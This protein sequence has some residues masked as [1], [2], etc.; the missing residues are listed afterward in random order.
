MMAATTRLLYF[1]EITSIHQSF[2]L[3]RYV[4]DLSLGENELF[5]SGL[6]DIYGLIFLFISSL[7]YGYVNVPL[8]LYFDSERRI[9]SKL[10]NNNNGF[11][12]KRG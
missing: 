8:K 2:I 3:T 11:E 7:F 1:M 6:V 5:S 4:N 12:W 10:C 9:L